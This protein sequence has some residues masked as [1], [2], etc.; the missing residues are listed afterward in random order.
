MNNADGCLESGGVFYNE[1]LFHR[2][3]EVELIR[4]RHSGNQPLLLLLDITVL[5]GMKYSERISAKI[6]PA[7]VSS[8]REIDITGWYRYPC[9]IGIIFTEPAGSP[10]AFIESMSP[11]L[12]NRFCRR[13]DQAWID[14]I[15]ASY[16]LLRDTYPRRADA[17]AGASGMDTSKVQ[18]FRGLQAAIES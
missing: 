17:D 2:N 9:I 15:K 18:T 14:G 5:T 11:K 13:L 6:L 4:A 10:E 8:L 3:L 7:V 1:M 12:Y 16:C